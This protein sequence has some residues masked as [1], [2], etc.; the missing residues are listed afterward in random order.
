[1]SATVDVSN[2]QTAQAFDGRLVTVLRPSDSHNLIVCFNGYSRMAH[3]RPDLP[4]E[5]ALMGLNWLNVFDANILWVAEEKP[6]WYLQHEETVISR[7]IDIMLER[8]I[9][10]IKFIGSSAGAYASIRA[11]LLLDKALV[12]RGISAS[13]FAFAM[14]PQT[15]FRTELIERAVTTSIRAGWNPRLLGVDPILLADVYRD[16]YQHKL[17]DIS[18][19]VQVYKPKNFATIL[20]YDSLNPIEQ[21]FSGD[22]LSAEWLIAFPKP[23]GVPHGSGCTQFWTE[24]LWDTFDRVAPFG[25]LSAEPTD[26]DLRLVA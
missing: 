11:G 6:T 4:F 5:T 22:I 12:E 1:M 15:G 14:N 9:R 3:A 21:V 25:K 26:D 18:D 20:M 24:Y 8:D 23:L 16:A 7:I 17:P 2:G 19:I 13:I 10:E